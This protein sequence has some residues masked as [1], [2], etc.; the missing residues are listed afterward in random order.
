[1][2][3]FSRPSFFPFR[4]RAPFGAAPAGPQACGPNG[5]GRPEGPPPHFLFLRALFQG[6]PMGRPFQGRPRHDQFQG[7]ASDGPFRGPQFDLRFGP[8]GCERGGPPV[9]RAPNDGPPSGP[10]H[11]PPDGHEDARPMPGGPDGPR[12]V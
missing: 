2:H 6:R 9:D 7:W 5:H 4:G 11:G 12:G 8:P 1:M 10:P 3:S